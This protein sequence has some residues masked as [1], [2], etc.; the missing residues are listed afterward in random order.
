MK[1]SRNP[2]QC[3]QF[4]VSWFST[5]LTS[6][7]YENTLVILPWILKT[8]FIL[9]IIY[10]FL[11]NEWNLFHVN[12]IPPLG[13][14]CSKSRPQRFNLHFTVTLYTVF[15]Q[16]IINVAL[17]STVLLIFDTFGLFFWRSTQISTC[18]RPTKQGRVK[19]RGLVPFQWSQHREQSRRR[20]DTKKQNKTK[21]RVLRS[22]FKAGRHPNPG[23]LPE[24]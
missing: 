18:P 24:R 13:G 7:Y 4:E 17:N 5:F 12:S 15:T 6:L 9:K 20:A 8:I 1:S 3:L 23:W 14:Y 2:L 10:C 22:L 16:I 11:M 19:C 21:K